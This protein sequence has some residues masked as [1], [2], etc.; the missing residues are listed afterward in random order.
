MR[1]AALWLLGMLLAAGILW[2]VGFSAFDHGAR[3][4]VEVPAHAD[5]IVALTGGA[6]RVDT[7]LGLL[8][9]GR[10][11]LLLISGVGR[12]ADLAELEHRVRLSADQAA[13]V[14]LGRAATSTLGNAEETGAWAR[15]HGVHSLIVVTAGY[16]MPRALVEIGRALPGI[17]LYPVPVQPPALRKGTEMATVRMLANE[18]NKYL[19]VRFGL[20]RKAEGS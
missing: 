18:Y 13:R 15:A 5:A 8:A 14:T 7:A 12:G 4:T 17:A 11:P 9:E 6:D 2:G 20:T 19:A 16:H 3:Q 10:A 1:R